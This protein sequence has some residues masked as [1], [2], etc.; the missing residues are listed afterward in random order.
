LAAENAPFIEPG[1]GVAPP[2]MFVKIDVDKLPE[3]A[4]KY[5]VLSL[6][7]FVFIKGGKEVSR[8]SGAN[9]AALKSTVQKYT[10]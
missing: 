5:G 1:A 6:P 3:A 7:T 10:R 4:Q 8:F 2:V 9:V